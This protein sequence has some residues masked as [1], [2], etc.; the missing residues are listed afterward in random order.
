MHKIDMIMD[1][2]YGS[3]GKGLIAGYLA[4]RGQYDTAVCAFATNAGH[5]YIDGEI[6]LMTQQLPTSIMSPTVKR[7]LL[8]PGSAIHAETLQAEIAR[9]AGHLANKRIMIH[10][11]AAVVED[12]H[13][14]YEKKDGRTKMG[15]TSKGVGEA[16]IERVRRGPNNNTVKNRWAS[17]AGRGIDSALGCYVVTEAEY[18]QALRE[19][20]C[21]IIEGAQGFSLSLYHGQY[22]YVTSRD[23]TPWQIAADCGIPFQW[24]STIQVIGTLR[25][26]PIRVNNR[27]GSSGPCYSDQMEVTWDEIGQKP[28]LTTVTKLQRRVFT[29][30]QQQL[31]EAMFHCGGYWNTRLFLN[32]CNYLPGDKELG[33]LIREIETPRH[34]HY[35]TPKV[36][37]LGFG[38][39]DS[40]VATFEEHFL[41]EKAMMFDFKPTAPAG[42]LVL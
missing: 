3:T 41:Q 1:F 5:T 33:H 14:D 42:G 20:E 4:K 22:P 24:S 19:S 28:E 35:V 37:W 21:M 27:D 26:F 12:Y 15:S 25:T 23:V 32:F 2:Q 17:G 9:Y 13:A 34:S 11:Q 10:P 6:H 7:V 29:F 30:S 18:D 36:E 16:Y 38:P 40:D 39:S 8:G 31:S